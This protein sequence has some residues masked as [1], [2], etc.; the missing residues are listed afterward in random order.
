M[1]GQVKEDILVR[2]GELG[3]FVNEGKLY[4][5]PWLL[6]KEEFLS[7]DRIF[8]YRKS[9]GGIGRIE[10]ASGQLAFTCC[11]TPVIYSLSASDAVIVF[12][13]NGDKTETEGNVLSQEI[14]SLIFKRTGSI[15][16]VE[17]SIN[18]MK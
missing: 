8:E 10:L 9:G 18:S 12:Y 13:A 11:Q 2:F 6:R 1:T 4:F 15:E 17:V 14:S 3:V 16:K 7:E 5:N